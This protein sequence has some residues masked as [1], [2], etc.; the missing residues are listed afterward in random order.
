[1]SPL[2]QNGFVLLMHPSHTKNIKFIH[3]KVI[4]GNSLK[5]GP[6]GKT[7]PTLYKYILHTYNHTDSVHCGSPLFSQASSQLC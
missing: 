6:Y 3:I 5:Y 1:M 2:Y 7:P 4:L